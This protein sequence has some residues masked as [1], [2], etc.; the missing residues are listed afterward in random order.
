MSNSLKFQFKTKK[1][2]LIRFCSACCFLI[3]KK[4]VKNFFKT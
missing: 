3:E 1:A 2:G 4:L